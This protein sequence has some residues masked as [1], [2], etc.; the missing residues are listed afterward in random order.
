M[1]L[2]IPTIITIPGALISFMAVQKWIIPYFEKIILWLAN[3]KTKH[4]KE[5]IDI[6]KE[7]I[8]IEQKNDNL[9][10]NQITFFAQQ[11]D[12]LQDQLNEKQKELTLLNQS[13]NNL[14]N[15]IIKL[16][17]KLFEKDK[18]IMNL[19]QCYYCSAVNCRD[20]IL[21]NK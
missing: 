13:I 10:Q 9:Y 20:R 5:S 19:K 8:T 11:I 17:E 21:D 6:E 1:N 15:Q 16:E 2:D 3:R 12:I 18:E 14:R 7:L 4:D